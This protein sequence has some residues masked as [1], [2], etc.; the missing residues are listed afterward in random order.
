M[1]LYCLM[2]ILLDILKEPVMT[3]TANLPSRMRYLDMKIFL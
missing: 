1:V 3:M 2:N